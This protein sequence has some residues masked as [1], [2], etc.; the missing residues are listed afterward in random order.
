MGRTQTKQIVIRMTEEEFAFMKKQVEKSGKSQAEFLR[1]A[2]LKKKIVS[3][4]GIKALLPELKRI[5]NNINQIARSCHKGNLD[6]YEEVKHQGEELK[7]VWQLL[8][9]LAQGQE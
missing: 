8:R 9:R 1:Q 4:D 6:T 3:T 7:E 5:G 2:I